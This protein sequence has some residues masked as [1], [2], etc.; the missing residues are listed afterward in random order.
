MYVGPWQEYALSRKSAENPASARA[1]SDDFKREMEKALLAGLDPAAAAAALK[2]ME[3]VLE[4]NTL[5]DTGSVHH[6]DDN[7]SRASHSTYHKPHRPKPKVVSS[8]SNNSHFKLSLPAL[9]RMN[10]NNNN[11]KGFDMY[12]DDHYG[13]GGLTYN[14]QY[15]SP[16]DDEGT[17]SA[18][19]TPNELRTLSPL[20]S[21]SEPNS[22]NNQQQGRDR[23]N[24]KKG[25]NRVV[26][27]NNK[28]SP[29][30]ASS[31]SS[32]ASQSG[33]TIITTNYNNSAYNT[34]LM[35]NKNNI[36]AKLQ[37]EKDIARMEKVQNRDRSKFGTRSLAD[38]MSGMSPIPQ[39]SNNKTL[40]SLMN[41]GE[42]S[43]DRMGLA[44]A[45]DGYTDEML[46]PVQQINYKYDKHKQF[47]REDQT[48]SN[49]PKQYKPQPPYDHSAAMRVLRLAKESMKADFSQFWDWGKKDSGKSTNAPSSKSMSSPRSPRI[50]NAT[51]RPAMNN[52]KDNT[53]REEDIM[54]KVERVKKMQMLYSQK[55]AE[56]GA[57][58]TN[59]TGLVQTGHAT[60][61]KSKTSTGTGHSVLHTAG[62]AI[63]MIDNTSPARK[64]GTPKISDM[65]LTD[66]DMMMISKYFKDDTQ[67]F[68]EDMELP[69]QYAANVD[70]SASS[71]HNVPNLNYG[72]QPIHIPSN[73]A[74]YMAMTDEIDTSR[75]ML[76]EQ[77]LESQEPSRRNSI[78]GGLTG[79]VDMIEVIGDNIN[80]DES[81][82]VGDNQVEA[83]QTMP[84]KLTPL[85]TSHDADHSYMPTPE[86]SPSGGMMDELY[87]GGNHDSLLKWSSK[88]EVEF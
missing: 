57:G 28:S 10:P 75:S 77:I 72:N 48:N 11:S 23:K 68:V 44:E 60:P 50:A 22:N 54:N 56:R 76:S 47:L 73:N 29:S 24:V 5:P 65:N 42:T 26:V 82:D 79:H 64:P 51:N 85:V 45:V 12:L 71:T 38:H 88:L 62:R 34:N 53:T 27:K 8:L 33:V 59:V 84:T 2:A 83:E 61:D 66:Q 36:N 19:T 20:S 3:K 35:K 9:D 37:R 63:A 21:Q 6:D 31:H 69:S 52:T 13:G 67:A 16:Q 25:I 40:P 74:D 80:N 55:D 18:R 49:S 32:G 58:H 17:A 78:S 1:R 81:I 7:F 15:R 46:S 30:Q 43:P 87:G 86:G 14:A 70:M 39:E 4:T 41:L